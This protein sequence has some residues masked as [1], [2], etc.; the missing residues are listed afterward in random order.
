[1]LSLQ[2]REQILRATDKV[3]SARSFHLVVAL[4]ALLLLLNAMLF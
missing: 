2:D 1:M 3:H 4:A